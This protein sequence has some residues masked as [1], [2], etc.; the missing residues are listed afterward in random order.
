MPDIGRWGVIDPLAEAS[1][2]WSPY[3]YAYS[4]PIHFIDPD[5]RLSQS[6]LDDLWNKSVNN[7]TWTNDGNGNFSD[8]RG[9]VISEENAKKNP[10]Y[11]MPETNFSKNYGAYKNYK[12]PEGKFVYY[13]N[14]KDIILDFL[15]G[16]GEENSIITSGGALKSV[17]NMVSVKTN[18]VLLVLELFR[19]PNKIADIYQ[20]GGSIVGTEEGRNIITQTAKDLYNGEF[21]TETKIF[22]DPISAVG[23]YSMSARYSKDKKYIIFALYN[24]LSVGS[25]LDNKF[26]DIADGV[27]KTTYQTYIWRVP[28][29]K[30]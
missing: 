22:T 9:H 1:R 15:R 24:S 8:G 19:N 21:L 10:F 7:T 16:E 5:G 30:K 23:S 20:E 4:N 14:T 27:R 28:V 11:G 25:G 29:N 6:F 26:G 17:K 12:N 13:K 3:N 2:R 18:M